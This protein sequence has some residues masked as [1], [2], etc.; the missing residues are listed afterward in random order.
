MNKL[1][2]KQLFSAIVILLIAILSIGSA[3][4]DDISDAVEDAMN[5]AQ[6]MVEDAKDEAAEAVDDAID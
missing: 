2:S 3:D 1:L 5:D 4:G 6:E